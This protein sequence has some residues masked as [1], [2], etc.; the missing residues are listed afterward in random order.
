[1]SQENLDLVRRGFDAYQRRDVQ[2][3]CDVAHARCEL[4][5]FT[6]GVVEGQPF[7]GH[8]GIADWMA[9]ELEPW[10]EW[11]VDVMEVRPVGERVL[12]RATV[13]GRGQ[14]S[15]AE[16]TADSGLLFEFQDDRIMRL[17]SYLNWRDALE[18][19]GLSE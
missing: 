13:T 7:R 11:R 8:A 12:A 2:A 10:D 17:W 6:V 16:L 1:M 9:H 5:T 19:V 3:M 15:S 14:G 4:F 18:A